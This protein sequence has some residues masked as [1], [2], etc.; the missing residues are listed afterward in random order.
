MVSA[1]LT[2]DPAP[3]LGPIL[4][5]RGARP[6]SLASTGNDRGEGPPSVQATEE[7]RAA[8]AIGREVLRRPDGGQG[9]RSEGRWLRPRR[10]GPLRGHPG[11]RRLGD[12]DPEELR[13]SG[14]GE[15]AP[16]LLRRS[17]PLN[18][19]PLGGAALAWSGCPAAM[20]SMQEGPR[21]GG[22]PLVGLCP[23]RRG[24]SRSGQ[25]SVPGFDAGGAAEAG[26]P[27]PADPRPGRSR[28]LERLLGARAT[29]SRRPGGHR[30]AD[31]A[32]FRSPGPGDSAESVAPHRPLPDPAG[33]GLGEASGALAGVL[34]SLVLRRVP[35]LRRPALCRNR[36]LP[37]LRPGGGARAASARGS[38][39]RGWLPLVA[40][41]ESSP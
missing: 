5:G 21:A 22:C 9:L 15:G 28:M 6:L 11:R 41:T 24:R 25:R 30:G 34:P 17:A 3:L 36:P 10:G 8:R 7:S 23:V 2:C 29:R 26:P 32:R 31:G 14:G 40:T 19:A 18:P 4:T 39:P 16:L 13:G 33:L 27:I 37:G 20:I 38:A 35:R 12:R 1:M